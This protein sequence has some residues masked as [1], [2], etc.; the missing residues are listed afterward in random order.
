MGRRRGPRLE[1]GLPRGG[2]GKCGW[3]PSL[4]SFAVA[5]L[6]P[7]A[8]AAVACW[9]AVPLCVWCALGLRRDGLAGEVLDHYV[10]DE[11]LDCMELLSGNWEHPVRRQS[12][13]MIFLG[14]LGGVIATCRYVSGWGPLA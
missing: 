3:L 7:A 6:A 14:V 1:S 9:L 4:G 13:G 12:N 2:L 5:W 10:D 11:S 8:P